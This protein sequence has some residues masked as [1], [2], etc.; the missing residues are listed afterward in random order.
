[1]LERSPQEVE[2]QSGEL[3]GDHGRVRVNDLPEKNVLT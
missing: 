2:R 3:A 1:M